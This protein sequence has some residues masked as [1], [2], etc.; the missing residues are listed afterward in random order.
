M[1][2]ISIEV[3]LGPALFLLL[4]LCTNWCE[5][6]GNA[7]LTRPNSFCAQAFVII[8]I[9][10]LSI[11]NKNAKASK[12]W[13]GKLKNVSCFS[14]STVIYMCIRIG[15]YRVLR[16]VR[17]FVY[18]LC[19]LHLQC[20]KFCSVQCLCLT[21]FKFLW[22]QLVLWRF[23]F[24]L[25]KPLHHKE[26]QIW[27]NSY[28]CTWNGKWNAT[29]ML[30]LYLEK[31]HALAQKYSRKCIVLKYSVFIQVIRLRFEIINQK[32][33]C[34]VLNKCDKIIIL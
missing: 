10:F 21:Y 9:A 18:W 3:S 33:L 26:Q 22:G 17:A 20:D 23:L 2:F 32:Y 13:L 31:T 27:L 19:I 1:I 7:A 6:I 11:V 14:P 5:W 8:K 12:K 34:L 4:F 25:Q 16:S 24:L 30:V 28:I 15:V 29:K